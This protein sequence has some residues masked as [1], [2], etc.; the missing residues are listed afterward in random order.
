MPFR[1][2]RSKDTFVHWLHQMGGVRNNSVE[3]YALRYSVWKHWKIYMTADTVNKKYNRALCSSMLVKMVNEFCE[4]CCVHPP[5]LCICN[6]TAFCGTGKGV[7]TSRSGPW[8]YKERW[9]HLPRCTS[10][11]HYRESLLS[12]C[13][14]WNSSN[15][16]RSNDFRLVAAHIKPSLISIPDPWGFV[17]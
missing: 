17:N 12:S 9:H 7:I 6:I 2:Q 5:L 8:I 13:N 11:V 1:F 16:C 4:S 3:L 10:T 15:S 14:M